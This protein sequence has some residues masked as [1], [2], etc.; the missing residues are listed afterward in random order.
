MFVKYLM[1]CLF[2]EHTTACTVLHFK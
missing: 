2:I 1:V